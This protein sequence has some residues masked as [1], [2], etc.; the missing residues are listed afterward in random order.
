VSTPAVTFVATGEA[1]VRFRDV[2]LP[3]CGTW[4]AFAHA[5][6]VSRA[7]WDAYRGQLARILLPPV[8][9]NP[10]WS[11]DSPVLWRLSPAWL[12]ERGV[13]APRGCAL[14]VCWHMVEAD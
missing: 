10:L 5:S 14:A 13:S 1:T 6:G 7:P 12:A 2:A 8:Q 4:P 9:P 11:C 3:S